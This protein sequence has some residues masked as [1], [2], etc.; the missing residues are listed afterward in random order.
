MIAIEGG[1]TPHGDHADSGIGS[2]R[3]KRSGPRVIYLRYVSSIRHSGAVNRTTVTR[4][5]LNL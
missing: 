3:A 5:L 1:P 2:Q 4:F